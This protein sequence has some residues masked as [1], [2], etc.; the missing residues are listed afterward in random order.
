MEVS[1]EYQK[2]IEDN[3][4]TSF[5]TKKVPLISD[6][7]NLNNQVIKFTSVNSTKD[8]MNFYHFVIIQRYQK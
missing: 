7:T 1:C 6:K 3:N 5:R 8:I 2:S 4:R